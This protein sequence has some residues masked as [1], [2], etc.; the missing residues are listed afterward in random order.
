MRSLLVSF[1][2]H[3]VVLKETVHDAADAK[4][5]LDHTWYHFLHVNFALEPLHLCKTTPV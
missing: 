4:R 2:H 3:E 5:G 1:S